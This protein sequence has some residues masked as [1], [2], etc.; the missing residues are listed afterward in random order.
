MSWGVQLEGEARLGRTVWEMGEDWGELRELRGG[1]VRGKDRRGEI[2]MR[3]AWSARVQ[4]NGE[5]CME[6]EG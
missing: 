4:W 2:R 6:R 5:R 1:G 3:M